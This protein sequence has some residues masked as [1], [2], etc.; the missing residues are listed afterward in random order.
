MPKGAFWSINGLRGRGRGEKPCQWYAL[1]TLEELLHN[2]MKSFMHIWGPPTAVLQYWN[3]VC[4][5]VMHWSSCLNFIFECSVLEDCCGSST[6]AISTN[7]AHFR[8]TQYFT[9]L[10]VGKI[11]LVGRT[12][13]Q[14]GEIICLWR[15]QRIEDGLR[16]LQLKIRASLCN[17][18]GNTPKHAPNV[19]AKI[20]SLP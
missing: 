8:L 11:T 19:L 16:S 3:L 7:T 20:S 4:T 5:Y 1:T 14:W 18:T 12:A 9:S 13:S 6:Y 2:G 15:F 10:H 17:F